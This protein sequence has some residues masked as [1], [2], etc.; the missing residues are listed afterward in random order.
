MNKTQ[1]VEVVA[2]EAGLKKKEADAAVSAVVAAIADALAAG[3]KVQLAGLGVFAVKERAAR[4]GRNPATGAKIK[5]AAAKH[6]GFTAG[7]TLKDKVNG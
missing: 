1:L 3:E 7:K 6:I 2:K 4:T 5:I